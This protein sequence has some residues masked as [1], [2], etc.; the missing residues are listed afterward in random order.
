[1]DSRL[2]LEFVPGPVFLAA[3]AVG[4]LLWAAAAATVAKAFAVALR[5][6]WDGRVPWLAVA[7]LA[8][9]LVLTASGIWLNDETYVLIRPTVGALAFAAILGIGALLRPSLLERTL[10]YVL[11]VEARAW[12]VLHIA[13]IV[14]AVLSAA[15]NE[16]ARRALTTDQWA[17]YNVLSDPVLFGL[18]W[19]TTR[20]IAE[21]Y[22]IEEEPPSP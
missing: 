4:G 17:V 3:N 5:W 14:I 2:L 6:R 7:T 19:L 20:L 10:D 13:W 21:H 16:V 18:I 9:A 11:R 15:A 8:L 12:P 22:W 1:M